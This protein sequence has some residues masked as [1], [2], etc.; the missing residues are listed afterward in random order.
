MYLLNIVHRTLINLNL[1]EFV[2]CMHMYIWLGNMSFI[3]DIL[4]LSQTFRNSFPKF[5]MK[6]FQMERKR[7][8]K[9]RR[10]KNELKSLLLKYLLYFS[11]FAAHI[12]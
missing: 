6:L 8:S 1:H 2:Q 11:Y 4:V 12:N 5:L 7:S 10:R 3:A 9:K